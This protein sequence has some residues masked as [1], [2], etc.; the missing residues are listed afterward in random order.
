MPKDERFQ[1]RC[2]H[3]GRT[4]LVLCGL[5]LASCGGGTNVSSPIPPAP[6]AICPIPVAKTNPTWGGDIHPFIQSSCGSAAVSCHGGASASGHLDFSLGATALHAAL[7]G[8]TYAGL[9]GWEYLKAGDPTKSWL[10]EKV[11]PV[12]PGEPGKNATG[13]KIGSQMPLGGSLC[14]PTTET[15]RTWILQGALDN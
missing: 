11:A 3:F 8:K 4:L 13:S 12:V 14:A 1:I 6:P 10:Y 9:A 7:V 15:L 2:A 5:G